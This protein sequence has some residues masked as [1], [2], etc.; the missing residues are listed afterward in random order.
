MSLKYT[1]LTINLFCKNDLFTFFAFATFRVI[2]QKLEDHVGNDPL[3]RLFVHL[4][5]CISQKLY[6]RWGPYISI[7]DGFYP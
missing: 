3:P 4:P 6:I 7:Q 1:I 2:L 5:T